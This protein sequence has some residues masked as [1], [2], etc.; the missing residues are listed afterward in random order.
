MHPHHS[1]SSTMMIARR[2][3]HVRSC[4]RRLCLADASQ[5][6]LQVAGNRGRE[7][8]CSGVQRLTLAWLCA[9]A[10]IAPL[11]LWAAVRGPG[12][13]LS[14][15]TC[16]VLGGWCVRCR[17]TFLPPA[18]WTCCRERKNYYCPS[19]LTA[20]GA[21][22][23]AAAGNRPHSPSTL[24][25]HLHSHTDAADAPVDRQPRAHTRAPSTLP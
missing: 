18:G 2:V 24:P 21:R 1:P 8:R 3:A 15:A 17:S 13:R 9:S 5:P 14:R 19:S 4:S 10:L 20:A 6:G 11:A 12:R 25:P 22:A 16:P 23:T 7:R